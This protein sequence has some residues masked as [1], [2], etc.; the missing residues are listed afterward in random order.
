[1]TTEYV[2]LK[3]Y[4]LFVISEILLVID[5]TGL[6]GS[7]DGDDLVRVQVGQVFGIREDGE[8]RLLNPRNL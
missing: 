8:H 5:E 4:L 3:F 1:M 2:K 7:S 6:I